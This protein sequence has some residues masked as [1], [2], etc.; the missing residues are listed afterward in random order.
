MG[1]VRLRVHRGPPFF[2]R[3]NE[4]NPRGTIVQFSF[5]LTHID[6][7]CKAVPDPAVHGFGDMSWRGSFSIT[8]VAHAQVDADAHSCAP[9]LH[10]T[11]CSTR[12]SDAPSSYMVL[13]CN[14]SL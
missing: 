7:L 4:N 2:L 9:C 1:N 3:A 8:Q 10:H 11:T 14:T 12:G 5:I 13:H 6:L